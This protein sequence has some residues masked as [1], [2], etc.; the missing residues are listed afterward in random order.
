MPFD[1]NR[2]MLSLLAAILTISPAS[3]K[4][5]TFVRS[6]AVAMHEPVSDPRAAL[7]DV[8][9]HTIRQ[10][11]RVSSGGERMRIVLSNLENAAPLDIGHV[12][13]ALAAPDG[14]IVPGSSR[15]VTFSGGERRAVVPAHSP[16]I[17]DTIDFPIQ[18]LGKVAVSIYLPS[19]GTDLATHRQAVA[20]GWLAPGDQSERTRLDEAKPFTMRVV[21][22][23]LKV[24]AERKAHT[25]VAFGDSIT[26]GFRATLDADNRWPDDLAERLIAKGVRSTAVANAGIGGNRLL[27]DG[28]GPNA[29]SRFDRDVLSVPGVSHV[30][31]LEGINDIGNAWREN[32]TE[33]MTAAR[34]IGAYRQMIER[35]HGKGIKVVLGTILPFKGAPYFSDWGEGLRQEVNAWIRTQTMADGIVDFDAAMR[36]AAEPARL[37]RDFDSGDFLHPNDTGYAAMAEAVDLKLFR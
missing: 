24:A 26:D 18:P 1:I 8:T 2:V 35:A 23:A 19:G 13:I 17:S 33:T 10:I 32:R 31:M 15:T 28:Y 9:D 6:W 20:T 34:L 27:T 29:L 7:P 12:E 25:V 11:V 30:V 36:D 4:N 14:S 5:E 21:L 3:A 22:T 16:F 37:R